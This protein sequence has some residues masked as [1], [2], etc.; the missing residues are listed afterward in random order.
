MPYV[1][2]FFNLNKTGNQKCSSVEAFTQ[3]LMIPKIQSMS[4][5]SAGYAIEL[6]AVK[7]WA[8]RT[9]VENPDEEVG[10]IRFSQAA[11]RKEAE[12]LPIDYPGPGQESR[13][14]VLLITHNGA[15]GKG[16][17]FKVKKDG[18]VVRVKGLVERL[19][20]RWLL[21]EGFQ[22]TDFQLVTINNDDY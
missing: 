19:A 18:K 17:G 10:Y 21:A 2:F 11:S 14:M 6:E 5:L 16:G 4:D 20:K 22:T 3:K 15:L 7:E 12:V 13:C 9:G 8:R 1:R